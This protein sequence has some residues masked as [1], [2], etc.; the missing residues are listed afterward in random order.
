MVHIMYF[1]FNHPV[2]FFMRSW[3]SEALHF[4]KATWLGSAFVAAAVFV[5][6]FRQILFTLS[7]AS[8]N[9]PLRPSPGDDSKTPCWRL[10][11]AAL[12]GFSAPP[13]FHKPRL[14]V[15]PRCVSHKLQVRV[16]NCISGMREP[17]IKASHQA[18]PTKVRCFIS[19]C[20]ICM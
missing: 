9:S 4:N 6:V 7:S 18:L 1:T 15:S 5:V 16:T 20:F 3:R 10:S 19:H 2:F 17:F 13:S 8:Q 11:G 14:I 12:S